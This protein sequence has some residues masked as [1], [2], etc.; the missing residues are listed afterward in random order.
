MIAAYAD[1]YGYIVVAP[2]WVNVFDKLYDWKGDQHYKVLATLRDLARHFQIN[3]NRVG[4]MGFGEGANFAMDTAASHPDYFCGVML[5]GP[6]PKWVNMMMH[7][8]RNLQKLPVYCAIGTMAGSTSDNIR[9]LYEQWMMRGFPALCSVYRGRAM[10]WLG[11]EIPDMFDWI[12]RKQ[13]ATG[14][15]TLRLN[16][17]AMEPWHLMRQGDNRF[18]WVGTD[19]IR[20]RHTAAAREGGIIIPATI[21]AD[22]HQG[23]HIILTTFGMEKVS[24]FFDREMIDWTKPVKITLNSQP[25]FGYKTRVLEPDLNFMLEN[26]HQTGDRSLLYLLNLD[27]GITP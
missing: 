20:D 8:W 16:Q 4:I 9:Q 21:K 23:N 1:R 17:F 26:L 5:M 12:S 27:V 6:N 19:K 15:Q 24:L 22:I 7:Y 10:E 18:Y 11:G 13:R 2:A 3:H 14:T 25:P